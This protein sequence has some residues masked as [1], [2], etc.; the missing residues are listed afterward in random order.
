MK[1]FL[2]VL[3]ALIFTCSIAYGATKQFGDNFKKV[4]EKYDGST[5]YID[6]T[7]ISQTD[8]IVTFDMII[9][10]VNNKENVDY[11]EQT[12]V[13]NCATREWKLLRL[14]DHLNN[15]TVHRTPEGFLAKLPFQ[16]ASTSQDVQAYFN[17]VCK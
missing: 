10:Y 13:Y 17:Y 5:S 7:T 4:L 6:T 1:K 8:D 15:G 12:L 2:L 11:S 14:I 9:D 3:T 16:K